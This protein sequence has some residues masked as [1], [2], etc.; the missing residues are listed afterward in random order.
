MTGAQKGSDAAPVTLSVEEMDGVMAG[1]AR[2]AAVSGEDEAAPF[3][4]GNAG[5]RDAAI[6]AVL[7]PVAE[8][9]GKRIRAAVEPLVRARLAPVAV[10]TE[11][12]THDEWLAT[13]AGFGCYAVAAM[14][15]LPGSIAL[16]VQPELLRALVDYTY[17]GSGGM[18]AAGSITELT[19]TEERLATRLSQTLI[20]AFAGAWPDSIGASI[21]LRRIVHNPTQLGIAAATDRIA[22]M[23]MQLHLPQGGEAMLAFLLPVDALATVDKLMPT[24]TDSGARTSAGDTDWRQTLEKVAQDVRFDARTI[25]ARP[26][27]MLGDLMRLSVGDVIPVSIASSSPL[28]VEDQTVAFGTIGEWEGQAALMVCRVDNR[29]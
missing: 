4:L 7:E 24:I 5:G 20:Q 12:V 28:I 16:S 19:L 23:R 11:I 10:N 8:R 3:A 18:G 9:T 1:F 17:G 22:V 15:P 14:A 6:I 2:A 29:D 13:E 26:E 25:L 27:L 21:D